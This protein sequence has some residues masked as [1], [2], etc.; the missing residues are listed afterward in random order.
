VTCNGDET[1]NE[2]ADRCEAGSTTCASGQLCDP[3]TDRCET[4]CSGCVIGGVCHAPGAT[5]PSNPCQVCDPASSAVGWTANVGASCDDGLF[6]T[7]D[8]TCSAAATCAG[9]A[10]DCADGVTCNGDETC[11]EATDRCAAGTPT[12]VG[13]EVCDPAADACVLTCVGG[14]TRCDGACVDTDHDPRHCGGCG[15]TCAPWEICSGGACAAA[16]TPGWMDCDGDTSNGCEAELESD[17]EN[18]GACGNVCSTVHASALCAFGACELTC[19]EGWGDCNGDPADGCETDLSSAL[20]HC[21]ACGHACTGPS[22]STLACDAGVCAFTVAAAD[23]ARWSTSL[24]AT[25]LAIWADGTLH[26]TG[27]LTTATVDPATGAVSSFPGPDTRSSVWIDGAGDSR[28]VSGGS[29]A[30]QAYEPDG[31][32][33][34]SWDDVACCNPD[35]SMALDPTGA[36]AYTSE[37][38]ELWEIDLASGAAT[39]AA[40]GGAS[41]GRDALAGTLVWVAG[42]DGRVTLYDVASGTAEATVEID[43]G[44]ASPPRLHPGAVLSDGSFVVSSV[45]GVVARVGTDGTLAW[46]DTGYGDVSA[47]VVT[48]TDSGD[49]YIVLGTTTTM[50]LG[51]SAFGADGS[52]VGTFATSGEVRSL[53]VA[54]GDRIYA[55]LDAGSGSGELVALDVVSGVVV[56]TYTG[57]PTS[58]ELLLRDGVAYVLGGGELHAIEVGATGYDPASPW[59]VPHH[60]NQRTSNAAAPLTY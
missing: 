39:S 55:L 26:A 22:G 34:W 52:Y 48:V 8:D 32:E 13:D 18:C 42:F 37:G 58:G 49:E 12:C 29:S 46:S 28:H 7:V 45:G 47:P 20:A 38:T 14:T 56:E 4:T 57:L 11:D 23:V 44:A 16:C 60:D 51:I 40:S 21:G 27:P 31:T 43:P 35:G 41:A 24:S 50:P 6:C 17:V 10:R 36:V 53:A 33:A 3:S 9:V 19:D 1:C 30:R 25:L 54:D 15:V 59:P 5:A 2:A